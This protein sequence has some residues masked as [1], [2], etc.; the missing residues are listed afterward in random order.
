MKIYASRNDFKSLDYY[1]GKP[2]WVKTYDA[3][4]GSCYYIK[5]L[6]TQKISTKKI[7]EEAGLDY[8]KDADVVYTYYL[9]K[10]I[11]AYLLD[12]TDTHF[13]SKSD[14]R[15]M[16]EWEYSRRDINLSVCL[17]LEILTDDEVKECFDS[18]EDW[19]YGL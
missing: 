13:V 12:S 1:I 16:L 5:V 2:V 19:D 10:R 7:V 8:N 4:A 15:D 18:M 6:N 14:Q 3:T 17:P 9:Y 11:P